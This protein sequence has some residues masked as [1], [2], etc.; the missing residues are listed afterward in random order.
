MENVP[1]AER[2]AFWRDIVRTEP[3]PGMAASYDE[4]WIDRRDQV[5]AAGIDQ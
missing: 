2:P 5:V 1:E 4:L 3:V